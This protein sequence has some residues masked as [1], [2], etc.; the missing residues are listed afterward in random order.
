VDDYISVAPSN[1]LNITGDLTIAMWI[2]PQMPSLT[3]T[4]LDPGMVFVS[5]RT[6]NYP[7]P[8][9]FG[10]RGSDGVL[11][12]EA[13]YTK[14]QYWKLVTTDGAVT[15]DEWQHIAVTRRVV[16]DYVTVSIYRNGTLLKEVVN[17][18]GPAA[19]N[20]QE[21][22]IN[23]DA[24]Y[25]TYTNEGLF[26]GLTD[27]LVIY[28]RAL[29]VAEVQT[30]VPEPASMGLLGLGACLALLRRKASQGKR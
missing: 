25:A 9:L 1:S 30:L 28:N 13:Y 19:T 24:Y 20:D 18:W 14:P 26:K 12:F 22:W 5:K 15:L 6:A 11:N 10:I 27:D 21:M 3:L 16:G 23:K 7:Q 4:G 2:R 29:S 8:Y 17:P